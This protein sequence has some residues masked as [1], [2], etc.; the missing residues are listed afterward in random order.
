M[1]DNNIGNGETSLLKLE[2]IIKYIL[3]YQGVNVWANWIPIVL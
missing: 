1:T 2:Y 3:Y